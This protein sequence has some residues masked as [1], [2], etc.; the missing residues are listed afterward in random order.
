[1]PFSLFISSILTLCLFVPLFANDWE[2]MNLRGR[3]KQVTT[4]AWTVGTNG[5][6]NLLSSDITVFSES[7]Y[8]LETRSD[9]ERIP[10]E[11]DNRGREIS[12]QTF[13]TNGKGSDKLTRKY[14]RKGRHIR[15]YYYDRFGDLTKYTSHWY[16]SE[17]RKAESITYDSS[18]VILDRTTYDYDRKTGKLFRLTIRSTGDNGTKTVV[19]YDGTGR[20]TNRCNY[21][22]KDNSISS[23]STFLYDDKGDVVQEVKF[24]AEENRTRRW[25]TRYEYDRKGNPVKSMMTE[26]LETTEI[27]VLLTRFE[28][29]YW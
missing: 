3:V 13:D 29:V 1:M 17:Q 6:T 28:Y 23:R 4:T 18:D 22:G 11:Y 20:E 7:G 26:A 9:T 10:H 24:N 14:D 15:D 8:V 5:Q 25:V 19:L 16:D 12:V 2:K 27:P 21:S